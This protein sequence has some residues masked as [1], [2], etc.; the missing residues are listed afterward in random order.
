MRQYRQKISGP[1]LDRIDIH[2]QVPAVGYEA[3]RD[4]RPAEPSAAIRQRV[5]AARQLQAER[6]RGAGIFCNAQLTPA[7]MARYCRPDPRENS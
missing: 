1:L 5:N 6:Y 7:M 2:V 3:L 4:R